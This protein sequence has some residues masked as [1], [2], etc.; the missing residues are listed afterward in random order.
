MQAGG[1]LR[2]KAEQV[3]AERTTGWEKSSPACR[4]RDPGLVG[5][6]RANSECPSI[7]QVNL[8]IVDVTTSNLACL[9][10]V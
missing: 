4:N 8:K 9:V 1:V 5:T 3:G 2:N 6:A 7:V 10:R